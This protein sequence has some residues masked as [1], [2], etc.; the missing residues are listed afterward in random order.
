MPQPF[1][2]SSIDAYQTVMQG[3]RVVRPTQIV[4]A[5]GV[6]ISL[7]QNSGPVIITG[8]V[9]RATASADSGAELLKLYIGVSGTTDITAASVTVATA[10][11]GTYFLPTGVFATALPMALPSVPTS[12]STYRAT[13]FINSIVWPGSTLPLGIVGSVATNLTLS[14]EW[15]L[16]YLPFPGASNALVAA[17]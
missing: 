12:L 16:W 14:I 9:G 2:P 13:P 8:L 10:V 17:V 4:P 15:T 5:S 1:T 3:I 11:A 6:S 7:F